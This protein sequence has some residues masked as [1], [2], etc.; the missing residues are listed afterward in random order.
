[1]ALPQGTKYVYEGTSQL[2]LRRMSS[3]TNHMEDLFTQIRKHGLEAATRGIKRVRIVEEKEAGSALASY[4]PS[5]DTVNVFPMNWTTGSRFDIP[6]YAGFGLRHW[7]KNLASQQRVWWLSKAVMIDPLSYKAVS[8]HFGGQHPY[9]SIMNRV[10]TTSDKFTAWALI[11]LLTDGGVDW[12]DLK[13]TDLLTCPY[14]ADYVK[15]RKAFSI[16]PLVQ[17]HGGGSLNVTAY[18]G[19]FASFVANGGRVG[20]IDQVAGAAM[21]TLF[22]NCSRTNLSDHGTLR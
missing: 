18:E 9:P 13:T 21:T 16:K 1:M 12:N 14:T 3:I 15:R 7:I 5:S 2:F 19:A 17:R 8:V 10:T 20:L 22:I 11:Q 6:F 4:D